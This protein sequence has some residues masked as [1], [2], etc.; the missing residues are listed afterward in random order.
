MTAHIIMDI[1]I[2]MTAPITIMTIIITPIIII[3]FL[4]A[5]GN[6]MTEKEDMEGASDSKGTENM[7]AG[8]WSMEAD[9]KH[10]GNWW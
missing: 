10:K 7:E 9:T 4:E 5:D 8:T 3:S 1:L 6:F 2:I